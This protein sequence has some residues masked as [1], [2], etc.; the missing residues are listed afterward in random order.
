MNIVYQKCNGCGEVNSTADNTWTRVFGA[1]K[2]APNLA[3][4]QQMP[5]QQVSG[6]KPAQID[7]CLKCAATTTIAQLVEM[8]N[9]LQPSKFVK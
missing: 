2:G 9:A 7:L 6:V 4:Q 1:F 5:M 3:P 8:T